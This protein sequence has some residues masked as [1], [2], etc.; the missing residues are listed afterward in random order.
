ML[1]GCVRARALRLAIRFSFS[2][3]RWGSSFGMLANRWSRRLLFHL[4]S[5]AVVL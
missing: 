3:F 4:K 1:A 2:S 5:L